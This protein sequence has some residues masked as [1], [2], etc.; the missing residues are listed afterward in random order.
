[1]SLEWYEWECPY[2]RRIGEFVCSECR[3]TFG[4][5]RDQRP[6]YCPGCGRRVVE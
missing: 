1:M 2:C 5:V 6:N 3:E 4:D